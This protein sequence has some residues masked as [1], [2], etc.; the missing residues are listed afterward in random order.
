MIKINIVFSTKSEN[1]TYNIVESI[2]KSNSFEKNK[3]YSLSIL[4]LDKTAE[5][6]IAKKLEQFALDIKVVNIDEIQRLEKKYLNFF[7]EANCTMS[8]D[9]IQRTRIQQQ[10]YIIDNY[11]Q[12]NGGVIWQVDDDMLFGRSKFTGNLHTVDYSV[13]YFSKLV[14]VYLQNKNIDAI[15]SPSTYVPPVP[16]LLYCESQL[17][18]YFKGTFKPENKIITADEYH[19]YYNQNNLN[20]YYNIFLSDTKDKNEIVKNILAGK[21]TSKIS[22]N[23]NI[24]DQIKFTKSK[25]FRGGNFIVFNPEIFYVPHLGFSENNTIPARRSDMIHAHLLSEMDFQIIDV[26]YFSL[27]HNR[28]FSNT[29]IDKSAEKYFSDMIGALLVSYLYKGQ[30]EFN[31]RIEFYHK[32]IKN[33]LNLLYENVNIDEFKTEIDRLTELDIQ[34]NSFDKEHFISEFEKFKQTQEQLKI[35]LCKLVS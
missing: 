24:N 5:Q 31:K 15:I 6:N 34:I 2:S 29:S 33:I 23:N 10:V 26:S 18:S 7:T 20:N 1:N 9:S 12:F 4:I 32:H 3:N 35:K 27:V 17:K 25:L 13:N 8:I 16:S 30:N 14:D 19:D 22:W 21:P 11:E 28:D